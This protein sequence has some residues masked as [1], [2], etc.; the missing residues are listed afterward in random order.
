MRVLVIHNRYR[1]GSPG[2][3]DIAV[4]QEVSLLRQFGCEVVMYERCNDEVDRGGWWG[5]F[6]ALA[7]VGDSQ[8]TRRDLN[9]LIRRQRPDLAHV[10]NLFP[11]VSGSALEVC[12]A[13]NIPLVQTLHNYRLACINGL[14]YR[15]GS[16]CVRCTG[17]WR[18][19]AV[20][21]GCYHDSRVASFA[22]AASLK[23]LWDSGVYPGAI[24]KFLVFNQFFADWLTGLGVPF[25]R[26]SIQPNFVDVTAEPLSS[27]DSSS[28]DYAVFC[29]R[30]APEKGLRTLLKAWERLPDLPLRVIGEG[31]LRGEIEAL[32]REKSLN[33][34]CLG[35]LPREE[36]LRQVSGAALQVVPS[37]WYEG[38]PLTILEAWA[39]MTPVIGSDMPGIAALLADGRGRIFAAGDTDGLVAEVRSTLAAPERA[40]SLARVAYQHYQAHHTRDAVGRHRIKLYQETLSRRQHASH[41]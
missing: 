15:D 32:I 21:H 20:W 11:L 24:D 36:V 7:Q 35:M 30:L 13:N 1:T 6:S 37:E 26:I 14:H 22:L 16:V 33:A 19:P 25:D 5:R 8:R 17:D 40:V 34:R 9:Q 10:H 31:P 12:R 23:K 28:D 18:W 3:E 41:G 29:G 4:D 39:C 27:K 38:M 2:G